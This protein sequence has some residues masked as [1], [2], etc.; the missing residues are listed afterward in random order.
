MT[1]LKLIVDYRET[2]LLE[3]LAGLCERE[4]LELGDV[5]VVYEGRKIIIERKTVSDL[6]ASIKDGRYREQKARMQADPAV[7]DICYFIEGVR[8]STSIRDAAAIGA[9]INSVFRDKLQVFF[10]TG[11]SDTIQWLIEL[12]TRVK[13]EPGKYFPAAANAG[14]NSDGSAHVGGSAGEEWIDN[15]K[16][17]TC[18]R[19]NI[20][21]ETCFLLQLA[22]IP[23]ISSKMAQK[24]VEATSCKSMV[25][26]VEWLKDDRNKLTSIAGFGPK[27]AEEIKRGLGL[28]TG[29]AVPSAE[30]PQPSAP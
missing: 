29:P 27:K 17:K 12:W 8:G 25:A 13:K 5:Q 30:T 20:T 26:F 2:A 9:I 23:G 16:I 7:T 19:E 3:G 4:N 6:V 18:R 11:T 24:L 1:D 15:V 10:T 14:A 22:Q 28:L 21:P